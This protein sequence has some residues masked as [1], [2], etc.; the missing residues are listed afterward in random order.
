MS[1]LSVRQAVVVPGAPALPGAPDAEEALQAQPP[2]E[3]LTPP[4][5]VQGVDGRQV[6]AI[7]PPVDVPAVFKEEVPGAAVAEQ[8]DRETPVAEPSAV[9]TAT[10]PASQPPS[11]P[12]P[13]A[14]AA[15]DPAEIAEV[16]YKPATTRDPTLSPEEM[17]YLE[18]ITARR[19]QEEKRRQALEMARRKANDP[20]EIVR[21]RIEVQGIL[22][23][24]EGAL[25]IVDDKLLKKGDIHLGA[26]IVMI[27]E[28]RVVFK[29]RG[30][31]FSK[32]VKNF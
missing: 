11:V 6:P 12:A 26:K 31:I 3:R 18:Q 1:S 24:Q 23:T 14:A 10:Q 32:S 25:A 13:A 9:P 29:F 15:G 4:D 7:L 5:P 27:Y 16:F 30:K 22:D 17:R 2:V 19:R 8:A 21:K 28:N 20:F